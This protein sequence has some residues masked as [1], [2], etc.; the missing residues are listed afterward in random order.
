MGHVQTSIRSDLTSGTLA[1]GIHGSK[2]GNNELACTVH[3]QV[4]ISIV[5]DHLFPIYSTFQKNRGA[6]LKLPALHFLA[7][8]LPEA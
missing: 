8:V 7:I 4:R 3:A 6:P 5:A 2:P 1:V